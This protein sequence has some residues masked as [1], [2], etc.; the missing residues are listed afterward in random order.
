MRSGETIAHETA[1]ELRTRE[2]LWDLF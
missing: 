2:H 1:A